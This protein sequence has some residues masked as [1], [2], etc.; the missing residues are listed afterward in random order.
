MS[1]QSDWQKRQIERG[2]CRICGKEREDVDDPQLCRK[3]RKMSREGK[4]RR[5][6]ASNG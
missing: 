1:R 3:H 2:N 5:R 4:A 6:A